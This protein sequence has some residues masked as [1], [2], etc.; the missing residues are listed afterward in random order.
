MPYSLPYRLKR[1]KRAALAR[2]TLMSPRFSPLLGVPAPL[3]KI[4]F[5]SGM[6]HK[7]LI[8][9]LP[10]IDDLAEDFEKQGVF[11][12]MRH[13]QLKADAVVLD[14]HYGYYAARV[15]HERINDDVIKTAR[16]AGYKHIWLAGISM[17]GFG[18][19]SYAARH[20]S[21]ISGLLLF[22][23]YLGHPALISEIAAAGGIRH[24]EPGHVS[25]DDYPRSVWAWFKHAL[26]VEAA[27]PKIYLGYGKQ[28]M[29]SRAHSLLEE[30]LPENQ[31]I[32]IAGGHD[33][34]TWKKI[35]KMLLTNGK[36]SLH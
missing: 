6:Q 16:D 3:R 25:K 10:G 5:H 22:A 27:M 21:Q 17:G 18:A 20:A 32:S 1:W 29:F 13:H 33:W 23:P 11:E 19:A 4:E 36:F 24:W 8:I 12:D 9:F 14:A 15:I 35:W 34:P 30:A 2:L 7:S 26:S 31:V 28:D